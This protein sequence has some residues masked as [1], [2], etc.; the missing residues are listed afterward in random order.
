M[1]SRAI[2]SLLW[3]RNA[4]VLAQY[5]Q[6]APDSVVLTFGHFD[7]QAIRQV[8]ESAGSRVERIESLL[9]ENDQTQ[10]HG[11]V[12]QQLR[13]AQDYLASDAW[14]QQ[15][16][17]L[18]IET[19]RLTPLLH[20]RMNLEVP[21]LIVLL[22]ALEVARQHYQID[23]LVASEDMLPVAKTAVLW[24]R[25]H[26]IPSLHL[27]HGVALARPY[28]VHEQ[29][30][31]DVLAVFGPRSAEGYL[32]LGL[33]ADRI[34][35]TG[36]PAWDHYPAIR[37]QRLDLRRQMA[38]KYG[39]D[40]A[41]PIV[42]FATTWAA[43]LT[44][45]ADEQIFGRSVASFL[46]LVR[47]LRQ[48]GI[49]FNAVIKDR[50]ANRDLGLERINQLL[51]ASGAMQDVIYAIEDAEAWV[52]SAD[53]VIG[54]DSNILVEAMMVGTPAINLLT[55]VGMRL[56]PSFDSESGVIE[57]DAAEL[58]SVLPR[59][60]LDPRYRQQIS[61]TLLA[62]APRYNIGVDG[63]SAARVA[64]LMLEMVNSRQSQKQYLWQQFLDVSD[65]EASGYHEAAKTHLVDMFHN[66]PKVVIDI[67][68]AA[69]A[70]GALIKQRFPQSKVWGFEL[71]KAAAKIAS[72][73]L[74]KVLVGKFEDFDLE[75]EGLPRGSVDGVILADVLEHMYNPWQVM[76]KLRP[77][78]SAKAQVIVSIPNVRNL[79]L[80]DD[81][82]KGNWRY[83]S[84]GLLDITHIRFFTYVE[85]LKFFGETGYRVNKTIYGIDDRLRALFEQYKDHCPTNIDTEKMV[86]KNVSA[87]ELHELCSLQFY[88]EVVPEQNAQ[89]QGHQPP[90][91][92]GF[93]KYVADHQLS[94]QEAQQFEL[95][96]AQ[97]QQHPRF[98]FVVVALDAPMELVIKTI[99][100]F[101]S[102]YYHNVSMTLLSD[103]AAPSDFNGGERIRWQQRQGALF[104]EI[105]QIWCHVEADWLG[106][107]AAGDSLVPHAL[108]MVG[109]A[110]HC[111]PD[112]QAIYGDEAVLEPNGH[113]SDPLFKPDFSIEYLRAL[114]YPGSFVLFR[115]ALLQRLNGFDATYAGNEI[116]DALLR[117]YELAGSPAIGHVP[118]VLFLRSVLKRYDAL[119]TSELV[120]SGQR[121]VAGHL[122]RLGIGANVQA[123]MLPG[124]Y[125]V[126]YDTTSKP[127]VSVI[128]PTKDKA[129]QLQRCLETLTS[130]TDYQQLEVLI[131]DNG[132]TAPD[133]VALLEQLIALDSA[134]LRV[135]RYPGE[136]HYG[137][138]NNLAAQEAQ[139]ELLLLLNNDTAPLNPDWL[140]EMVGHILQPDVGIVGARLLFPDGKVQQAGI[141]LG[142]LGSAETPFLGYPSDAPGYIGRALVA[143]DVSAVSASCML[144]R[145]TAFMQLAGFDEQYVVAYGDIDL[146]LR[147]REAGGRVVWTP[148]ASL[149]HDAGAS[150][151]DAAVAG[152]APDCIAD[153]Q[154]ALV[155]HHLP[156]LARDPFYS[157]NLALTETGCKVETRKPLTWNPLSW[158]PLPRILAHPGDNT[159]CGHY[160]VIEP[161]SAASRAGK[162]EAAF[163][164]GY[165]SPV[166]MERFE[167]DTW[168]L[169]RQFMPTQ[170]DMLKYYKEMHKCRVVFELDDLITNLPEKNVHRG[171]IP[172][173]VGSWLKDA[174]DLCDR[175]VV[176][177][178]YL[179]DQYRH[180]INDVKV[181]PNT[182]YGAKWLDLQALRRTSSK[183]RV[184]WG[185]GISHTGDLELI[186]NVVKELANEVD[187]VFFG[188]C[189]DVLRPY[190]RE[191]H[192][193]V[194]IEHYPAKLA[195]LNL[196]LAIAPLEDHPFN[197]AKSSLRLLEYGVLGYP[198]ICTDI[199]PY[200]GA[201]PV[202]RVPNQ[203]E[204]WV[205]AI[206]EHIHDL[207]ATAKAGD[208]LRLH[209]Q[210]HH[211]LENNL[212]P[213]MQ[214][215]FGN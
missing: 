92:Q 43:N 74:D 68:C 119:P 149:L 182:I 18:D 167:I 55:D 113:C 45:V 2:I 162:V 21:S 136:F 117:T 65:I 118:E 100:A 125:R 137:R 131:V 168:Y 171:S 191:F 88:L 180:L 161:L 33:A 126:R 130:R 154:K 141:T 104:D 107:V 78:L 105:N 178:D 20:G 12:N 19:E 186:I 81:L 77:Y 22:Q 29:V 215:W 195:S 152:A 205:N 37:S 35:L 42:V 8:V 134:S 39:L 212:E 32:D 36:N 179:A 121:A 156:A 155:R 48:Q 112:W 97:W 3:A 148:H 67:G 120:E 140:N 34:K 40:P 204:A 57:V 6:Q 86:L 54:I 128:I 94:E 127:L 89:A 110:I 85:L 90:A 177:T 196:D 51:N 207:D 199:L 175:F 153:D 166:E 27:L 192:P 108:L 214:A 197:L 172:V 200:Q 5:L 144:I 164:F 102:Q 47:Q 187:W 71:N 10:I 163:S 15:A 211:L 82:A 13:L 188:M 31:A 99:K 95:R 76:V 174:L 93:D 145:K 194:A 64:Q 17:A 173:E 24:A 138:I 91:L 147:W 184:G 53:A 101:T 146:C 70:T 158:K 56:G 4:N 176:T 193:G 209:V 157:P 122:R 52:V 165:F 201:F 116:Y 28:T 66:D 181:V 203:T 111:H 213:W 59:L 150:L 72:S 151:R 133:A 124:S 183:P 26:D 202:V 23:L 11:A 1:S 63:Q 139:G 38:H 73:R 123:G 83:D 87:T 49:Q 61:E 132:S 7:S 103:S 50:A 14:V 143:Q 98:H 25:K 210:Q 75:L 142:L 106:I 190:I 62:H 80:M 185:G 41:L 115:Q 198:V 30:T 109:E 16:A 169:Q 46:S 79:A 44:A 84:W 69:G 206:R 129:E 189:P 208:A 170:R 159:G 60:L 114:P 96:M 135:Y 58:E 9:D 160:R